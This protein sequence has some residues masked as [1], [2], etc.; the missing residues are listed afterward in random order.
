MN[1][2]VD[3]SIKTEKLNDKEAVTYRS[4]VGSMLY[5]AVKTVPDICVTA[6]TLGLH[7]ADHT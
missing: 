1:P 7:V 5:L 3:H 6:N 4:I 2:V